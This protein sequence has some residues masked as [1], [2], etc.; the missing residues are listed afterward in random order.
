MLYVQLIVE[1]ALASAVSAPRTIMTAMELP[2][3]KER[4]TPVS[5]F[6]FLFAFTSCLTG[7]LCIF[8]MIGIR[9]KTFSRTAILLDILTKHFFWSQNVR[10]VMPPNHRIGVEYYI[11]RVFQTQIFKGKHKPFQV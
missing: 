3:L 9:I 1:V 4:A 6:Y 10:L 7:A 11:K 8:T 5:A 2:P